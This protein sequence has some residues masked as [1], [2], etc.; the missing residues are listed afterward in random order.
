V[1]PDV[2]C[3]TF[4]YDAVDIRDASSGEYDDWFERSVVA[5]TPR[6]GHDICLDELLIILKYK[7]PKIQ[8]A[9]PIH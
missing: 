2:T 6:D 5:Q 4:A 3:D 8:L 9:Y 7:K 1:P